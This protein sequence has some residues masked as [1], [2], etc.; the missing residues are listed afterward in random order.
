MNLIH[1]Q[2]ILPAARWELNFKAARAALSL[3]G[4]G[5]QHVLWMEFIA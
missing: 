2:K 1:L 5:Q 4:L 3:Q